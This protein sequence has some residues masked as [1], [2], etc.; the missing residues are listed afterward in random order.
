MPRLVLS[1]SLLVSAF[2]VLS[3]AQQQPQVFRAGSDTVR[4]FVTATDKDKRLVTN[5]TRDQFEVRDEGKPQ[6][7]TQFDNSPQPIH[8]IVLLD[9]SGSMVGNLS[10][11]RGAC[12]ELFSHLGPNDR[13]RVGSF[14]NEII[15]SPTFTRD[16]RALSSALPMDIS[17]SAST[18]LWRAMDTA[19]NELKDAPGRHVVL[20]LSD[21]KDSGTGKWG[22]KYIGQLDVA[23]RA[24]REDVLV[25]GIGVRSRLPLGAAQGMSP[26][27]RMRE[28]FPDPG[29]SRIAEDT[30]GGYFELRPRED[31]AE[32]FARVAE[33]LHSQYLLGFTTPARDGKTHEI[34]VRVTAK[35]VKLRARK[36]YLAPKATR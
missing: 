31:L 34:S 36:S 28:T 2:S 9:V 1:L 35:D 22:Q 24:Q 26:M 16:P 13:A 32:A 30:G 15:I 19:M 33:E 21:S 25:Y 6:P 4:V 12:E 5:L 18:P 14:G 8:L 27:D 10:V 7:L 29:L 17:P 20:V 23:E 11:L 3:G